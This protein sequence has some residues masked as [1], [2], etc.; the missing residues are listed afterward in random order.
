LDVQFHLNA[1]YG[2]YEERDE[3]HYADGVDTQLRHV[4]GVLLE[5]HPHALRNREN[6]PHEN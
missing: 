5:E 3:Q 1:N 4:F 6:P 2:T